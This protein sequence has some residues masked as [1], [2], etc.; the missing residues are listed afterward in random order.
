MSEK[1]CI[2]ARPSFLRCEA[3]IGVAVGFFHGEVRSRLRALVAERNFLHPEF[4]TVA[5]AHVVLGVEDAA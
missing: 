3:G 2:T 4:C 1:F 5:E